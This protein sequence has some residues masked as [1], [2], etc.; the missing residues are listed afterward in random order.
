MA[1]LAS[2]RGKVRSLFDQVRR[3]DNAGD[4]QRRR[5]QALVASAEQQLEA[6]HRALEAAERLDALEDEA[7]VQL[8]AE[9]AA[10]DLLA[11]E[12]ARTPVTA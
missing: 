6:A 9:L 8:H 5:A 12:L 3:I 1:L 11:A 4:Q 10:A 2:L 7:M